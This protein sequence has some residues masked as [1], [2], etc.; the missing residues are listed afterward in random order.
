MAR[1]AAMLKQ[2][3]SSHAVVADAGVPGKQQNCASFFG[4]AL[5][6]R[7]VAAFLGSKHGEMLAVSR[8]SA[9]SSG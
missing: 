2:S 6:P 1:K 4:P 7:I 5:C 9:T 3:S 8:S